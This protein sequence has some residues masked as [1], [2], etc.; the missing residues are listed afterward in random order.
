H[1]AGYA[2]TVPAR[3]ASPTLPYLA[4]PGTL[5]RLS[6]QLDGRTGATG[7]ATRPPTEATVVNSGISTDISANLPASV[8]QAAQNQAAQP[9]A[10][11]VALN[12][13]TVQTNAQIN[14]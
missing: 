6:T 4:P 14:T 12:P 3:G 10:Q 1:R 9:G 2:I 5:A 8:Q 7:G 13:G 11:L